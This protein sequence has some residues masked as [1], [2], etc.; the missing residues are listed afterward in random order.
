[1]G[2]TR[3]GKIMLIDFLDKHLSQK[4]KEQVSTII[5]YPIAILVTIIG[6]SI[7]KYDKYIDPIINR[8]KGEK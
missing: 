4:N 3:K 1:L 7:L 2:L 8:I 5:F 6:F